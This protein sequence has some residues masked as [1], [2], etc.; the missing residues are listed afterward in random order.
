MTILMQMVELRALP[1]CLEGLCNTYRHSAVRVVAGRDSVVRNDGLT[2]R[3]K[4]KRKEKSVNMQCVHKRTG[5]TNS[6]E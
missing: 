5:C 6:F 1:D 3:G 4:D 2:R